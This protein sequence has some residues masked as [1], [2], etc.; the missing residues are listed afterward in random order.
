LPLIHFRLVWQAADYEPTKTADYQSLFSNVVLAIP[1]PINN[2]CDK[3]YF[4]TEQTH[5]A[6]CYS[7][8]EPKAMGAGA[9]A[10]EWTA[11][12]AASVVSDLGREQHA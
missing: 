11:T 2:L 7:L 6:I 5:K 8:I 1:N 4:K 10:F 9:A 12:H 3:L